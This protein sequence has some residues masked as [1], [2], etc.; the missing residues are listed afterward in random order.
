[1]NPV[2]NKSELE[3]RVNNIEYYLENISQAKDF[4][5]VL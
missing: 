2:N 4:H 5:K 3:K 1:M